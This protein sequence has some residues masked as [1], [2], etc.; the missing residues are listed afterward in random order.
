M[1]NFPAL[2]KSDGL[3]ALDEHLLTRS[4][5]TGYQASR[6]DLSVWS[7]IDKAPSSSEFPHVTRWYNHIEALLKKD[8]P[9]KA[10]GVSIAGSSAPLTGGTDASAS[11][12]AAPS[13]PKAAAPVV[14]AAPTSAAVQEAATKASP[15]A[16][17][18][19]DDDDEDVD[20]FGEMT[21][22]EKKAKEE[23]DAVIAAAKKRGAEKAKLT[24]SLIIMDVKPWDDT[25]DM[26]ALEAEV[27]G[28]NKDG[29]LWGA[30]KLVPVGF[31]IK[32]LQITCVIEDAKVESMDAVIE[33]DL[34]RDGESEYIQS[35]DI[36]AFNKL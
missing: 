29:L 24:K 17:D 35:V 33:D 12:S 8:F 26:S 32:K 22:E 2:N 28:V 15:P 5:I 30:S 36:Q 1:V 9:G 13:A 4:Y 10:E 25:T 14:A 7:A 6:D 18:D 11:K 34:V 20:L 23:K 21:E 19:D 16:E 31:G 27:R 3:K